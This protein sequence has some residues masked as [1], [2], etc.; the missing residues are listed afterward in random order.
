MN[1][2]HYVKVGEGR[3]I[4]WK[5]SSLQ[6][7]YWILEYTVYTLWKQ[8]HDSGR[9]RAWSGLILSDIGLDLWATQITDTPDEAIEIPDRRPSPI[10]KDPNAISYLFHKRFKYRSD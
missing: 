4:Q 8:Q 2:V 1:S 3:R 9:N 7:Y 5:P 6:T 10:R